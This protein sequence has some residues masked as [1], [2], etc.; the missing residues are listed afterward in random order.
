MAVPHKAIVSLARTLMR[1][2]E[3]LDLLL[4]G[5]PEIC[6]L[7]GSTKEKVIL[8]DVPATRCNCPPPPLPVDLDWLESLKTSTEDK[9]YGNGHNEPALPDWIDEDPSE[10]TTG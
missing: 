7:C 2:E 3:K 9:N 6:T 5:N 4:N 1:V 10:S 8:N